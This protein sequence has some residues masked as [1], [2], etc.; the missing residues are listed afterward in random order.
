[1]QADI[2]PVAAVLAYIAVQPAVL[3]PLFVF[4]DGSY[5]IRDRLVGAVKQTLRVDTW[6]CGHSFRIGAATT[7]ALVEI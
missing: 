6:Y 3:G 1:M 5:L 4:R 2:C 7:A